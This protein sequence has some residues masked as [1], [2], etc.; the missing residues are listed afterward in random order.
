MIAA[1]LLVMSGSDPREAVESV[2]IDRG[3]PVPETEEQREWVIEL[4]R[5]F[6]PSVTQG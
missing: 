2:S 3:L 1:S 4:A 5:E 6:E